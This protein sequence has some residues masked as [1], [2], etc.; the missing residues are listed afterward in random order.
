MWSIVIGLLI[1][2]VF[3]VVVIFRLV[4]RSYKSEDKVRSLLREKKVDLSFAH[5]MTDVVAN[6]QDRNR[7]L[8]IALHALIDNTCASSGCAFIFNEKTQRL[9]AV[10]IEGLFPPLKILESKKQVKLHSRTKFMQQLMR[11]E[12]FELGEGIPGQVAM[13]RRGELVTIAKNDHRIPQ[14]KDPQLQIQSLIAVPVAL[15]GR[16]YGV[17]VICSQVVGHHFSGTNYQ[18]AEIFA[19][20]T[21]LALHNVDSVSLKM[22]Q[23]RIDFDL[24]VASSIQGLL[25]PKE[26]PVDDRFSMDVFYRTAQR[27][28][29]DLYDVIRLSEDRIGVAIADVSGKGISACLVMAICQTHLKH[30]SRHY[31]SP[32]KVLCA[33]NHALF[34]EIRNDMFI[35]VVYAVVDLKEETITIARAGHELPLLLHCPEK[36]ALPLLEKV[37]SEGMALGMVPHDIF[38]MVIKDKVIPFKSGDMITLYTDGITETLNE[39][40]QEFTNT[41]LGELL[42][43]LY[44]KDAKEINAEVI[45][46]VFAF[47]GLD[48]D[49]L[50][51]TDLADD[52]T[53]ITIKRN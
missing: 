10:I 22:E 51:R 25:L 28:G 7:L 29:G 11:H 46:A 40:K 27:V 5:D 1:L 52:T 17:L 13:M 41:R 42:Q 32:A 36:G 8:D 4:R 20:Q 49:G 9:N 21:A 34:S 30:F 3:S 33:I 43:N 15:Q 14:H 16:L 48:E 19:E 38:D 6:G 35:T 23:N 24:N 12:E 26:L 47:K 2:L 31:D 50:M 18:R 45:N 39:D 53:L 37:S 44:S